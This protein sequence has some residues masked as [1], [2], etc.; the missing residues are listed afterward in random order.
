MK[1]KSRND[2]RVQKHR[3]IRTKISGTS[4]IPRLCVKK[5]HKNFYA[6]LIDDSKGITLTSVST[7]SKDNTYNGNMESAIKVGTEMGRN[8]K[9]IKIESIVFDRS[10]YLYH[11]KVKA[12]AE[13]VRKEGIKF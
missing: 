11:G 2:K 7:L 10:G 6:Q 3:K 13:A 8:I 1:I 4:T 12:F 9:A 5:S